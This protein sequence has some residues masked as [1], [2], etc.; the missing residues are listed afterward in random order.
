MR[1]NAV[2]I[3]NANE[4][5]II[6]YNATRPCD[7]NSSTG[8]SMFFVPST[9][10]RFGAT[11]K[12][13]EIKDILRGAPE[14]NTSVLHFVHG[15]REGVTAPVDRRPACFSP[16]CSRFVIGQA[17]FSA[18]GVPSLNLFTILAD[19]VNRKLLQHVASIA[20]K[21]EF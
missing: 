15:C 21:Q 8:S 3:R 4:C 16:W 10:T 9:Y 6:P 12:H 1:Y 2:L 7:N 18:N 19:R 20:L 11:R 14:Q 17:M 13:R 5:D